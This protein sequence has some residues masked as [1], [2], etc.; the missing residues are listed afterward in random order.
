MRNHLELR[1]SEG[2]GMGVFATQDIPKGTVI[3]TCY[4][5]K[6]DTKVEE[7]GNLHGY[8]FNYPK[9]G[10]FEH[11]VVAVGGYGSVYNHDDTHNAYWVDSDKPMHFDYIAIK[12]IEAGEEVCVHYGATYWSQMAER[13]EDLKKVTRFNAEDAQRFQD[14]LLEPP[15]LDF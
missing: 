5:I 8:V 14:A 9:K 2:K 11:L 1:E 7:L 3:E 10:P 15:S 12:D 13:N 6:V 4:L